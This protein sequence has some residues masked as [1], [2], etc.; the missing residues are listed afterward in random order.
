MR[1]SYVILKLLQNQRARRVVLRAAKSPT[2]RKVVLRVVQRQLGRRFGS[3]KAR[4]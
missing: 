4:R 3:G 1:K 2:V